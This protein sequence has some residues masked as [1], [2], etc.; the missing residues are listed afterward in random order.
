MQRQNR[1]QEIGVGI[2][3]TA[4][5]ASGVVLY[6][7][8]AQDSPDCQGAAG[9]AGKACESAAFE[10]YDSCKPIK[11]RSLYECQDACRGQSRA[12]YQ[13]RNDAYD[14]CVGGT[15]VSTP[16]QATPPP[17][18]TPKPPEQPAKQPEPS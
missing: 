13:A 8:K 10:C 14:A 6:N 18:T 11:D 2:L 4:V 16:S 17:I 9:A 1:F 15:P 7:A 5:I 3:F 12:C